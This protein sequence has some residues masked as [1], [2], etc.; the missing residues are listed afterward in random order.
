MKTAVPFNARAKR[1]MRNGKTMIRSGMSVS[2]NAEI[3]DLLRQRNMAIMAGDNTRV[4]E[5]EAVIVN[6]QN[7]ITAS[8][9]ARS[10]GPQV[11]SGGHA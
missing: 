10:T 9:P 3:E 7:R 11:A 4:N 1:M 2:M 6:A 5:I 8:V